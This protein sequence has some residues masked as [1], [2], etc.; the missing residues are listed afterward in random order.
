LIKALIW[1]LVGLFAL[2]VVGCG[3]FVKVAATVDGEKITVG[4]LDK[5]INRIALA[6]PESPI[7]KEKKE[8][9]LR[10]LNFLIDDIIYQKEAQKL[11]IKVTDKEVGAELSEDRKKFPSEADFARSLK[12]AGV[13][14]D[15]FR[16][17]I[18][19]RLI[20]EAVNEK[21][22]G[23]VK[24]SDKEVRDYYENNKKLFKPKP[25]QVKIGFIQLNTLEEASDVLAKLRAGMDFDEAMRKFSIDP[26]IKT[27]GVQ[28]RFV[29]RGHLTRLSS[30]LDHTAFNTPVGEIT[31]PIETPVGWILM[32]IYE[33]KLATKGTFEEVKDDIEKTLKIN[34]WITEARK[35]ANVKIYL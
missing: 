9:R 10:V 12:D 5:A 29:Q 18:R 32:K 7:P 19:I 4:E 22:V 11:A 24:V 28:T 26:S 30:L 3:L 23:K 6:H 1:I 20:R 16:D 34:K 27:K 31:G 8:A 25:E 15:D 35:Q 21:I 2:G 33:K 13:T 14:L 17:S